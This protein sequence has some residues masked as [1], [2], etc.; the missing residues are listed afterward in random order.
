MPHRI[1]PSGTV[2]TCVSSSSS[3]SSLLL[4]TLREVLSA[5][6]PNLKLAANSD[7]QHTQIAAWERRKGDVPSE[8]VT[9]SYECFVADSTVPSIDGAV[10]YALYTAKIPVVFVATSDAAGAEYKQ[11]YGSCPLFDVVVV[12][13]SADDGSARKHFTE[14]FTGFTERP[15]RV[16]VIEGGDGAGKQTQTALLLQHIR[17]N[18]KQRAV[19]ID[20]PHDAARYG[21]LIREA[22]A[23]H[24]GDL[25][26]VSPLVFGSLYGLNRHDLK[27][28]IDH[29]LQRGTHIIFDRWMTANYGHQASKFKTDEERDA[30]IA[31][32]RTFEVRWLGLPEAD[33]VF[34]LDLPPHVAY[35][36]MLADTTRKELDLHEKAGIEYKENVRRAFLWCSQRFAESWRVVPC[37][38]EKAK[39]R[40]SKPEVHG[41]IVEACK[42]LF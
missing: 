26:A 20:F 33:R 21:V 10:V 11:R 13:A 14:Y 29:W 40:F 35:E 19:T 24:K 39:A 38:D 17:E 42:E 27:P 30:A 28:W 16:I 41:V 23:G 37:Y 18:L 5:V 32:L 31:A 15:G 8:P 3:S 6:Q 34:Y 9:F 2:H 25:R 4:A 1:L 36:A 12:V 22:L 7:Q